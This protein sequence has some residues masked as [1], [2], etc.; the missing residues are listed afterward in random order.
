MAFAGLVAIV[1]TVGPDLSVLGFVLALGSAISWGIGN[2]LLKRIRG[3]VEI[4]D[5][6][7]WLSLVP[8]VPALVLSWTIDG[9]TALPRSVVNAAWS[10]LGAALYLGLVATILAYMIWGR[11]LRRYPAATV[12]P[13]AL[14]VPF[15]GAGGSALVFGERFGALRIAGMALVLVGI[16]VIVL[17]WDRLWLWMS[18]EDDAAEEPPALSMWPAT[19]DDAPGVIDL[20]GRVYAEYNFVYDPRVEVPDLYGFD[21]HY[22]AP[23]GGF[24]VVREGDVIV[25]SVGVERLDGQTAELHRLYLDARLRGR[26]T[27]RALVQAALAWCRGEQ[28][29]TR[30]VLWSDTRFDQAHRLYTR[31][32]FRRTGERVLPDDVNQTR[33]YGFERPV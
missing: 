4:L 30:M 16:A 12:T 31:M 15:V 18:R 33:E 20:I 7:I 32:G 26:G 17:P 19:R 10:S 2:V 25:G 3:D 28:G 23:H 14:L 24:F 8:P 5:L 21:D 9:P 13:F 29:I 6:V 1:F 22:A 27:G 11:L